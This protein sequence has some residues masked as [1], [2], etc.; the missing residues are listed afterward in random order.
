MVVRFGLG[1][2]A[3]AQHGMALVLMNRWD[4]FEK[5]RC[6]DRWT[7]SAPFFVMN[8]LFIYPLRVS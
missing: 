4:G 8:D 6:L 7:V 5:L 1:R 2:V 3:T